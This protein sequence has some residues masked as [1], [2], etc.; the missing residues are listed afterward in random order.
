MLI[1]NDIKVLNGNIFIGKNKDIGKYGGVDKEGKIIIPF[2]Y[3]DLWG[4]GNQD[5]K[6]YDLIE[7]E[8]NG[9]AGYINI[10]GETIIPF[11]YRQ[12]GRFS[13]DY[14]WVTND[15]KKTGLINK[16]GT[17][18]EPLTH[19]NIIKLSDGRSVFIDIDNSDKES[20]TVQN[21]PKQNINQ[22]WKHKRFYFDVFHNP[23][24]VG[25]ETA[26]W[27]RGVTYIDGRVI[28]PAIYD[29]I[30]FWQ[31]IHNNGVIVKRNNKYGVVDLL[32]NILIPF[33]Y[34]YIFVI[35]NVVKN[36]RKYSYYGV[37][38]NGLSGVIDNYYRESIPIMYSRIEYSKSYN[39]FVVE[40]KK[41]KA[42]ID[43]DNNIVV[44]FTSNW[45]K[46]HDFY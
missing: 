35:E 10:H 33:E 46:T 45:L 43:I 31:S 7:A 18:I 23:N 3:D 21:M 20:Y 6:Y 28:L 4:S 38:R 41:E 34:D 24:F 32:N 14:A 1:G 11:I 44:P 5:N 37:T 29:D 26:D 15:E 16:N 9:K 12:C 30:T 22:D 25:V 13:N 27:K 8:R 2:V 36:G 39:C 17:I 40:V 19:Y 42:M